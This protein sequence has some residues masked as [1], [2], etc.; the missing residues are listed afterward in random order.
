MAALIGM[1][2]GAF[3]GHAV[4]REWGAILG[5]LVGFFVG[6]ALAG[7]RQRTA[8]R[9]PDGLDTEVHAAPSRPAA[10]ASATPSR[11]RVAIDALWA[12]FIGGNAL[13]RIGVVVL[14]IGAR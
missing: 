10:L 4:W 2:A 5:G 12:W 8:H 11:L 9:K 3:A 7:Q 14:F 1:V 6:A 13:T